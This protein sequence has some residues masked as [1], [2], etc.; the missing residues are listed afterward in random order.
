MSKVSWARTFHEVVSLGFGR[1]YSI[2]EKSQHSAM[3]YHRQS[4]VSR[5][6]ARSGSSREPLWRKATY[7]IESLLVPYVTV[8]IN[9]VHGKTRLIACTDFNFRRSLLSMVV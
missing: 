9:L 3:H 2:V 8:F 4:T 1:D 5:E 6:D 7:D